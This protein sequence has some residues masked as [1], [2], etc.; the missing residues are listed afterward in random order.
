MVGGWDVR[1][2]ELSGRGLAT[3]KTGLEMKSCRKLVHVEEAHCIARCI[4]F[5]INYT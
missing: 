1:N 2:G 4:N 5:L 3:A